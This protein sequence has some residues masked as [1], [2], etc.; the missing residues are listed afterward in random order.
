MAEMSRADAELV[1]KHLNDR[2]RAD[3]EAEA[4]DSA[5]AE[6]DELDAL[7][8]ANDDPQSSFS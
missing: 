4:Y 2:V 3:I 7:E 6:F 8:A 1:Y 5:L